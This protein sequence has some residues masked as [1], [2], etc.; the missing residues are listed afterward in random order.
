MKQTFLI[1]F[2]II[3]AYC[4]SQK[5]ADSFQHAIDKG[6]SI[7]RLDSL[8]QSSVHVD[9]TKAAFRG[10][11]E[12][13]VESYTALIKSLQ[14]HLKINGFFWG[15][16]TRC[17]NRVYFNKSGEI[18]YFLFNFKPGEIDAEKEKKFRKLLYEFINTYRFP[19]TNTVNFAQCSPVAYAD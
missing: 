8:Y 19:L 2:L 18:D 12:V 11:E 7:E 16:P 9:S 1:S 15:K 13:F 17:F 3:N 4:Y 10:Q 5:M 14:Y 6:V